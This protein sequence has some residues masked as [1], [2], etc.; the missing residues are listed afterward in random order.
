MLFQLT[1]EDINNAVK[2]DEISPLS[3]CNYCPIQQCISRTLGKNVSVSLCSVFDQETSKLI[4]ELPAIA[5]E[6]TATYSYNWHKLKP[7]KFKM[8]LL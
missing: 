2:M 7:L 1:Q 8:E 6:V 3:V 5:Q 4:A